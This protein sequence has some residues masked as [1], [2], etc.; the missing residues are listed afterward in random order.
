[1][2]RELLAFQDDMI[3]L[4]QPNAWMDEETI[5]ISVDRVLCPYVETAPVGII[6]ILYLDSYCC[7]MMASV[8]G[9]IQDIGVEVEH[10]PGGCTS[11]CQ[12]VDIGIN[13]PFKDRIRQQ[14][15]DWM[16]AEGLANGTT[17]PPTREHIVA[18]VRTAM[19]N[20]PAQM[21]R[22]AWRH[23]QYSWFLPVAVLNNEAEHSKEESSEDE[24]SVACS[25]DNL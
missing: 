23:G 4:C 5:P 8:V 14:W 13:K 12:P 18:W 25:A 7:H 3:Y 17:S 21:I 1:V 16:I 15:E 24:D 19:N 10:I 11:L 2:Q 6:P 22:N 20:L 9:K